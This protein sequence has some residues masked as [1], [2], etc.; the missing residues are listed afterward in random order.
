MKVVETVMKTVK[1]QFSNDHYENCIN[2]LSIPPKK[3]GSFEIG[4]MIP[5]L[6][7]LSSFVQLIRS[8]KDKNYNYFISQI[9][10]NMTYEKVKKNQFVVKYG[11]KGTTF[12]IILTGKVAIVIVKNIKCLLNEEEYIEHLLVLRKNNEMELLRNTISANN[13]IF[14]IEENLDSWIQNILKR[15]DDSAYSDALIAKMEKVMNYAKYNIQNTFGDKVTPEQYIETL[16]LP[17]YTLP[18]NKNRKMLNIPSY[19][20]VNVFSKGQTFGY[21]ALE[22]KNQKRTAT[23]ISLEDCEFGLIKKEDYMVLLKSVHDKSRKKFYEV[24]YSFSIFQS[25]SKGIFENYYY[26]FFKY[27]QMERGNKVIQENERTKYLYFLQNGE[28]AIYTN[29]SVYDINLLIIELKKRIKENWLKEER[30]NEDFDMSRNF[31]T[32]Y[33]RSMIFKKR[34]AKIGIIKDRDVI[35]LSD[36]II[37]STLLSNFTIECQSSRVEMFS[38]ERGNFHNIINR[39]NEVYDN[40]ISFE[41]HKIEFLIQRLITYKS[42]VF[43]EIEKTEFQR[44]KSSQQIFELMEKKDKN[45]FPETMSFFSPAKNLCPKAIKPY[46]N[47]NIP[48]S[49]PSISSSNLSGSALSKRRLHQFKLLKLEQLTESNQRYYNTSTSQNP[50]SV[51][52]TMRITSLKNE[53]FLKRYRNT[54]LNQNLF[55]NLFHSYLKP[56]NS[57]SKT[58]Q[59]SPMRITE[60]MRKTKITPTTKINYVDCLIMDKFNTYYSQAISTLN[61]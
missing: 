55:N 16:N 56:D 4:K 14:H 41:K 53:Q 47:K 8:D 2:G 40:L 44:N 52:T 42:N 59:K 6:E 7:T 3:R 49:L 54:I 21:F 33:W 12:Y 22:N 31:K 15:K 45:K 29:R 48:H 30:E 9:S 24:I 57:K 10:R 17:D 1:L 19:S 61:K 38:I 60:Y 36:L 26:N 28:Y 11:E 18:G 34:Q 51:S 27:V 32:E 20:L 50:S 25:I 5:Y 35:G 37:P 39:E 23:L 46:K 43:D 13:N 58:P